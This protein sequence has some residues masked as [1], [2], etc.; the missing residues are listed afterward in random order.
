MQ[1]D[2]QGTTTRSLLLTRRG[3]VFAPEMDA[4]VP[5]ALVR[6]VE[7][8]L[9][10]LGY[11]VSRRLRARLG[12]QTAAAMAAL[13]EWLVAKLAA[14]LGADQR[15]VPLFRSFP[16]DV[17]EDTGALWWKKVLSHYLQAPN[18]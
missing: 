7:L 4:E 18:Q 9:A 17:P 6:G 15:H 8:E 16:H 10:E 14:A 3:L 1:P 2:E 11:V 12:R 5:G 13:R